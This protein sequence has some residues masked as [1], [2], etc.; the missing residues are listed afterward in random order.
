[1][2]KLISDI[3]DKESRFR[4][5]HQ[6]FIK[7]GI[8]F[9]WNLVGILLPTLTCG[10]L[11][12]IAGLQSFGEYLLND[13]SKAAF[14][15]SSTSLL[16]VELIHGKSSEIRSGVKWG[17]GIVFLMISLLLSCGLAVNQILSDYP[18]FEVQGNISPYINVLDALCVSAYLAAMSCTSNDMGY[19]LEEYVEDESSDDGYIINAEDLELLIRDAWSLGRSENGDKD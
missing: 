12:Q 6:Y 18:D 14:S 7:L 19:E 9:F 3:F 15:F 11:L 17:V 1:M 2:N 4:Q 13:L 8:A 10:I 5:R 16:C